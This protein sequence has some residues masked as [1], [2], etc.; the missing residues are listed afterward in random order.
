MPEDRFSH[1]YATRARAVQPSAIREICALVNQPGMRSLAGGWPDPVIFPGREVARVVAELMAEEAD[2]V[3]QYGSTEGLIEL[4]RELAE[5]AR[6]EGDAECEPEDI[7]VVHGSAQGMDLAAR[8]FVEPG[9]VVMVGLPTYFGGSGAII[10]QGGR[11]VGVPVD[12]DGM[13]TDLLAEELERLKL[14][15]QTVKGVYVIP[16]FQNPTGASLSLERRRHLL[17]L[18]E[19]YDLM[20]FEDDPYGELRYEGRPMPS[21]KALDE[22][23]RVIHIRSMSK[24]FAPGLRLGWLSGDSGVIRKLAITKQFVD[25]CTNSLA[26]HV[27]YRFLTQGLYAARLKVIIDHYRRKRD[28]MLE[29]LDRHFPDT[30]LWNRP[31]GGFFVWVRLP[32]GMDAEELLVEAVRRNVVFVA[33]RSFFVDGSGKNTLRLSFAQVGQ[34]EIEAAVSELGRLI[35]KLS[36]IRPGAATIVEPAL[37]SSL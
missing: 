36:P 11:V 22:T 6:A 13:N 14:N 2:G 10:A 35:D 27:A 8:V 7:L 32:G 12:G 18:A 4:R 29:L 37:P 24:T 34:A 28:L 3:L 17:A 23:G 16:N 9:D 25:V 20:I 31:Q 21:L 33:G 30:V 15:G 1:L 19:R 26:Q 5:M